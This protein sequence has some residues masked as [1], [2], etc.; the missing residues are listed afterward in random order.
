MFIQGVYQD[1]IPS[2][3]EKNP[4]PNV[5]E[6]RSASQNVTAGLLYIN[7]LVEVLACILNVILPKKISIK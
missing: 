7:Q 3:N 5:V 6:S 1:P 4:N 2:T